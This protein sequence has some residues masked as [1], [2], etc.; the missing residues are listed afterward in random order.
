MKWKK[1]YN[2]YI[3]S[4]IAMLIMLLIMSALV[5]YPALHKI[6]T[7]KNEIS[8]EKANLEKK[9]EMGLNAKKI[10]EDLALVEN[11]L[12]ILDSIFIPKGEELTLLSSIEALASKNSVSV[13]LKPDFKGVS[14][15]GNVIR[16]PLTISANGNFK[17]LM[18]F[19]NDLDGTAF[20]FISDQINLVKADKDN[21]NLTVNGQ[22][23]IRQ[24]DKK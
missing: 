20:Y 11:K 19:L 8:M 7:I 1:A 23:Y 12:S 18:S 9:L 17:N 16:T 21:I 14:M 22:V 2:Y 3:G 4:S 5:I 15:A 13:T 6:L 10:K 24:L